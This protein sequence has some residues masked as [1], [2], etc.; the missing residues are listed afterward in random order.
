MFQ[1]TPPHGRRLFLASVDPQYMIVS[2]HASAREATPTQPEGSRRRIG[3]NPRLRTGGDRGFSLS[4][5]GISWV[6]IHAS[7]REAT[8]SRCF[9]YPAQNSFNPRLRTGGD[10]GNACGC[11]IDGLVSI[12]ASAREATQKAQPVRPQTTSFN[13]RLRTGGDERRWLSGTTGTRFQSTPPHG[14]RLDRDLST[15]RD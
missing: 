2:I 10:A 11:V 12:H 1:S 9:H 6:S 14:R 4:G 13:P 15:S 8:Y 7:A 5:S 3:F